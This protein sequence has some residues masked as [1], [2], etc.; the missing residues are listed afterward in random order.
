[1]VLGKTDWKD[2]SP[3]A[4]LPVNLTANIYIIL[5]SYDFIWYT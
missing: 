3:L 2:A 5:R 1:M 4:I